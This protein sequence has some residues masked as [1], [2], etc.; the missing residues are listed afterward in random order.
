MANRLL[1]VALLFAAACDSTK[2]D[3]EDPSD[4]AGDFV[5]RSIWFEHNIL[6]EPSVNGWENLQAWIDGSLDVRR[7]DD[8][9]SASGTCTVRRRRHR[10]W[11]G[12]TSDQSDTLPVTA[13]GTIADGNVVLTLQGCAWAM[14][15]Y[16]GTFANGSYSLRLTDARSAPAWTPDIWAGAVFADGDDPLALVLDRD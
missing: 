12:E 1:L 6:S 15:R 4:P 13:S 5:I 14:A 7:S 2:P 3:V 16:E 9:L 10:A 11:L 8:A